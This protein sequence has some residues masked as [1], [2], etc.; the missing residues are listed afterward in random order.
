MNARAKGFCPGA[1]RPMRSGDGLI[2][3]LRLSCNEA[4]PG[5]V[6]E[7]A[8]WAEAY[9][10]G[11]LDVSAR[12]N[13]QLRGVRDD[14]LRELTQALDDA[15]LLDV[16][17]EAE[18]VRNVLVAPFAGYDPAAEFDVREDARALERELAVN[19]ALW[20]L[21]TKFGFS[22]DAGAFPLGD[23]SDVRFVAEAGGYVVHIG[24]HVSGTF[25]REEVVAVALRLADAFL[26]LRDADP[27]LTR[28]RDA[29]NA[30][31]R[32]GERSEAIHGAA[33][34]RL[35]HALAPSDQ[36]RHSRESGNPGQTHVAWPLG[37]RLR[38][39]DGGQLD[40]RPSG[41][42]RF[43][44]H[45][46]ARP[47]LSPADWLGARPL[48]GAA[49]VGV[50]A[51]FGRISARDLAALARL[52]EDAG[53]TTLRFA[54][55]RAILIPGL[56]PV[57][58]ARLAQAASRLDLILDPADPRLSVAACTGAPGCSS[59]LGETRQVAARLARAGRFLHVSGC[60]KGCAHPGA[61]P[62]TVVASHAGYDLVVDGRADAVPAHRAL[63]LDALSAWLETL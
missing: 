44:R 18:A 41:W 13:L 19:Q 1:L 42:L 48:G 36:T 16:S 38:G 12:G 52:A 45:D 10:N 40:V 24:G 28:M 49:F 2:V 53:A 22:F 57:A 8:T 26:A 5:L 21:P 61:A 29:A 27:S 4:A 39:D 43:A 31:I 37:P 60:P 14:T 7:I 63:S 35:K 56:T 23:E 51:P 59:A 32:H 62:F 25:A 20:S 6:R 50:A 34:A 58:A 9:G 3:R 55:W 33:D 17:A 15:G 47:A 54:P 30:V 11:A 46:G